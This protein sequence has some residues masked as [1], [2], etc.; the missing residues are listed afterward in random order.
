MNT[1]YNFCCTFVKQIRSRPGFLSLSTTDILCGII[2]R[3][4]VCPGF[5]GC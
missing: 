3:C 2:P 4:G 5:V 1:L